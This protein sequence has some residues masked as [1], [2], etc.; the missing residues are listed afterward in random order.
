MYKNWLFYDWLHRQN[1]LTEIF[2]GCETYEIEEQTVLNMTK[3]NHQ[4]DEQNISFNWK[5]TQPSG[6]H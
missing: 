3:K 6:T 4:K 2:R 1:T 5:K